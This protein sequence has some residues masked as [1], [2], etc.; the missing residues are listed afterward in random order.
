MVSRRQVLVVDDDPDIRE[1]LSVL[2]E[3]EGYDVVVAADGAQ[4]VAQMERERPCFVILDLMM[5]VMD[6]WQVAAHMQDSSALSSIP[7][8]IV[9]AT[10]E[11]AP[12]TSAVLTKPVNLHELLR[13]VADHCGTEH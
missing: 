1:S 13:V 12:A 5:P 7:M 11:W 10:P 6:G 9:T 3:A 2:L 4:A 8:C